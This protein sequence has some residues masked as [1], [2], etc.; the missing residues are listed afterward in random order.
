MYVCIIISSFLCEFALA[1]PP[2]YTANMVFGRRIG[3]AES[4]LVF[5]VRFFKSN[6]KKVIV[7]K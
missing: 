3:P 4:D 1:R 6:V 2:A 5:P 7:R